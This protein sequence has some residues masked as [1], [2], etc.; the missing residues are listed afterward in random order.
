MG[1]SWTIS[2]PLNIFSMT[3][4]LNTISRDQSLARMNQLSDLLSKLSVSGKCLLQCDPTN[5]CRHIIYL[6]SDLLKCR[7][8]TSLNLVDWKIT[9]LLRNDNL[10]LSSKSQIFLI[11]LYLPLHY[12]LQTT[13]SPRKHESC[14]FLYF[15]YVTL[16]IN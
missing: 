5:V 6:R 4:K 1:P 14:R 16:Q 3:C 15:K 7:I 11:T 9:N 8:K 10:T 12:G 13:G 2:Y